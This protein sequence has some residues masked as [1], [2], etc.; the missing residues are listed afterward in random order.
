MWTYGSKP[1]RAHHR[2]WYRHQYEYFSFLSVSE[3]RASYMASLKKPFFKLKNPLLQGVLPLEQGKECPEL[4]KPPAQPPLNT[5]IPRRTR[6]Q[7]HLGPR[8]FQT[9]FHTW[10]PRIARSYMPTSPPGPVG[11]ASCPGSSHRQT[12]PQEYTKRSC[13]ISCFF[14]KMIYRLRCFSI[15]KQQQQKKQLFYWRESVPPGTS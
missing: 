4:Q 14:F 1:V 3:I 7:V 2:L 6:E 12:T 8:T 10:G 11:L 13:I 9:L 5:R 15:L